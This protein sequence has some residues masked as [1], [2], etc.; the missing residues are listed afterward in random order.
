MAG[1]LYNVNLNKLCSMLNLGE[2]RSDPK[3]LSGGLLHRMFAVETTQGKYAVKALNP[4]IMA[5]PKA[6]QN[7]IHSERI[8]NAAARSD[9][10][11]LPAKQFYGESIQRVDDQYYLV[12]DWVEGRSLTH[13]DVH[14]SHCETIGGILADIHMTDFSMLEVE[15]DL[16]D[17]TTLAD[18][19]FYL[20]QGKESGS[21]WVDLMAETIDQL[22]DWNARAGKAAR[23]LA[24]HTVICH[25]DLDSK[26]VMWR[27]DQPILIDWEAAGYV[28]PMQNLAETAM[29]WSQDE[30][31]TLDKDRFIAFL[32]GYRNRS[33]TIQ[34]D[35]ST[36][37]DQ[38]PAGMLGWLEYNLKRSLW[39]EC[40]DEAEQRLGTNEVITALNAL[41]RYDDQRSEI[42]Q[43]LNEGSRGSVT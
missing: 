28:N 32:R 11:A 42:E 39:I 24:S 41:K 15:R 9:I 27:G 4:Q 17:E 21:V 37:L 18:W 6:L 23:E 38:G 22:Y 16:Q 25:G 1:A 36:V 5:R 8:A 43:W 7:T 35:W 20:Q 40:T 31:G 12:F 34:A 3:A 2:M 29:H 19:H 10:P 26:N 14:P 13:D 30:D 33:G